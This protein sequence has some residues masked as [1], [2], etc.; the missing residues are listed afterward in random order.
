MRLGEELG[1][2]VVMREWR[3]HSS[4][5]VG[6]AMGEQRTVVRNIVIVCRDVMLIELV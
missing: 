2:D 3:G 1:Y 5:C 4:G 6:I